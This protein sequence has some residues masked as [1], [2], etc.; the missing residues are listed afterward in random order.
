MFHAF[1]D[2]KPFNYV[3][4]FRRFERLWFLRNCAELYSSDY[5][6]VHAQCF[7]CYVNVAV[8]LFQLLPSAECYQ[9]Q[10]STPCCTVPIH[11]L[12]AHFVLVRYTAGIFR[13]IAKFWTTNITFTSVCL[14]VRP[15][16]WNKS[17]S[18]G[19]IF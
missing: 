10:H 1:P 13:H 15:S 16:A 14:S 3:S 12:S 17:A 6:A 11:I 5:T 9:F 8:G 4:A 18:T 2:F 19:Q 7:L